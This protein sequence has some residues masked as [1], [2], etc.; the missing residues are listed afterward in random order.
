ME[1]EDDCHS[2]RPLFLVFQTTIM[3]ELLCARWSAAIILQRESPEEASVKIHTMKLYRS[4][5]YFLILL[6][7]TT[8]L[9]QA[10]VCGAVVEKALDAVGQSCAATGRNQACY[11][12]VSLQA[13]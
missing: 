8:I 2:S 12:F 10:A 1:E 6:S 13:T 3:K 9:A 5:A 11:G 4:I 7:F